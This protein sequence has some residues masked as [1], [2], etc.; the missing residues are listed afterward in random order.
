MVCQYESRNLWGKEH[1]GRKGCGPSYAGV[2]QTVVM[3][4]ELP[5][6]T[7][8]GLKILALRL[9]VFKSQ[10]IGKEQRMEEEMLFHPLSP[11]GSFIL[12][13]VCDSGCPMK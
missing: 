5:D 10:M 1:E 3:G 6:R 9:T 2:M 7:V 11:L 4:F 12:Y 8:V 13:L